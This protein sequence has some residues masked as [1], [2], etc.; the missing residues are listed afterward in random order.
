M[1]HSAE[2]ISVL[3]VDDDAR[4]AHNHHELITTLP[5]FAVS[6]VAHTG[7]Q[8]LAAVAEHA[9]HLV[10][11]DLFLPDQSGV[12][13][14]R[15]LR[16]PEHGA[17]GARTDVLVVTALRDVD[18]VRAALRGGAVHYLL[19]PCTLAVLREQLEHYAS[20]RSRLSGIEQATQRDVDRVF[21]TLR[22]STGSELP[23]GLTS[24]TARLVADTVRWATADLSA[25]QVA[26]QTGVS[27]VTA[28]RYLEH[29]CANGHVEL[30]MRY[31]SA[32]RP[33]HRYRWVR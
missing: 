25:A 32:G 18:N 6:G 31:G 9:P 17:N 10:L 3:I 22:P 29:L 5:G 8:A 28:R 33:E 11:L 12:S 16:G 4:V 13:V 15:E 30:R 2:P 23:K 26:E 19:K 1:E 7:A 20:T 24:A 21:G 14:L 27:R